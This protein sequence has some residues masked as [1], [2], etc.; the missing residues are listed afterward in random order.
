MRQH[1][2]SG[3]SFRFRRARWIRKDGATLCDRCLGLHLQILRQRRGVTLA[4]L[5]SLL[6]A[7][8]AGLTA[9]TYAEMERGRYLPDDD[10]TFLHVYASVL[11]LTRD[12]LEVLL[13]LW[14]FAV[15]SQ[16]IGAD[17]ARESL[18]RA[19]IAVQASA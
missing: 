12:E 3:Q 18:M 6:E 1:L 7:R 2:C 10:R 11:E 17:W 13:N 8:G 9:A 14:A 15:L 4:E 5:G 19:L 16:Q